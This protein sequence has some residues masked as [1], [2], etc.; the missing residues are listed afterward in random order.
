M[1]LL[2]F[3]PAYVRRLVENDVERD[4]M[5]SSVR[6]GIPNVKSEYAAVVGIR[7]RGLAAVTAD[8]LAGGSNVFKNISLYI[9][10]IISAISEHGGDIAKFFGNTLLATFSS[11]D[12]TNSS[13][14]VNRAFLLSLVILKKH[15]Y[16]EV[17][18]ATTGHVLKAQVALSSG[19]YDRI[20]L[21][22]VGDRLELCTVGPCID[23]LRELHAA[24]EAGE[25]GISLQSLAK[26][27]SHVRSILDSTKRD[28]RVVNE[29][30]ILTADSIERVARVMG[31]ESM[32]SSASRASRGND[33][34]P[35]AVVA[36]D[37]PAQMSTT[38][39]GWESVVGGTPMSDAA[40]A[41]LMRFVNKSAVHKI[42]GGITEWTQGEFM[43]VTSVAVK[44]G[45]PFQAKSAQ[46][47]LSGFLAV[48]KE[49]EGV[50][51][52]LDIDDRGQTM[53]AIFGL[54]RTEERAL[55]A[56][57]KYEAWLK[58][59]SLWGVRAAVATGQ[60]HFSSIGNAYRREVSVLGDCINLSVALLDADFRDEGVV[61]DEDTRDAGIKL[62]DFTALGE[63]KAKGRV[64]SA[65]LFAPTLARL[66]DDHRDKQKRLLRVTYPAQRQEI[67]RSVESY[68]NGGRAGVFLEG[69]SG[70]GK[71]KMT[72]YFIDLCQ[73]KRVSV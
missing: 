16:L 17:D 13:E 65:K 39:R 3:A 63:F 1:N 69:P 41:A 59:K 25:L 22:S 36:A 32:E 70:A 64:E 34:L 26:L 8:Q 9:Q 73:E 14:I 27:P 66:P 10:K 40:T 52:R 42:G 31:G 45:W 11:M 35:G 33:A 18:A 7:I 62:F 49:F 30:N 5:L 44:L 21:G 57:Q 38:T 51:M 4:Q 46:D 47:A 29:F 12:Q 72:E 37:E 71:S 58:S 61:C 6:A 24:T 68:C 19:T 56:C 55:H 67:S 28:V 60:I 43:K 23:E 20:V 53:S 50:F 2:S 48:L 15:A 54:P